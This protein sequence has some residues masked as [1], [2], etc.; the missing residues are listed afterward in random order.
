MQF[1]PRANTGLPAFAFVA[2]AQSAQ[3]SDGIAKA[4]GVITQPFGA[5]FFKGASA[6]LGITLDN[7]PQPLFCGWYIE[8][9]ADAGVDIKLFGFGPV[10]VGTQA[11]VGLVVD[12]VVNRTGFR[13][14]L[15]S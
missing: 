1:Y 4:I 10:E 3:A 11:Q 6:L 8:F 13:G 15:N 12:A 5:L 9:E 2:A 14:G 7:Q